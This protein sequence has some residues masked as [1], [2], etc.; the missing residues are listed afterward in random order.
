MPINWRLFA[1]CGT[2]GT[3]TYIIDLGDV[4]IHQEESGHISSP[5]DMLTG[6]SL[7]LLA[8]VDGDEGGGLGG[9]G[10]DGKKVNVWLHSG[11]IGRGCP[12][13]GGNIGSCLCRL[14]GQQQGRRKWRRCRSSNIV[15]FSTDN[16]EVTM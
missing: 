7:G 3:T 4:S 8:I 9:G 1:W 11:A 16:T 13:G 10:D 14:C 15:M 2:G 5:G 6:R 12:R